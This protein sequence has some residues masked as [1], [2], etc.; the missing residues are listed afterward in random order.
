M[1]TEANWAMTK[2]TIIFFD[3]LGFGWVLDNITAKEMK[4]NHLE[5]NT[6]NQSLIKMIENLLDH[7]G[8]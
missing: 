8:V 4:V 5:E 2:E 3:K 7:S 6:V 1:L